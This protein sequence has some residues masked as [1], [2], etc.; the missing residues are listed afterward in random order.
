MKIEQIIF[1]VCICF[2]HGINPLKKNSNNAEKYR[3]RLSENEKQWVIN[4]CHKNAKGYFENLMYGE[5]K[6]ESIPNDKPLLP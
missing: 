2:K 3:S 6:D 4:N 5:F 1:L